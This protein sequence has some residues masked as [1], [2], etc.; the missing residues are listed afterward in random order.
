MGLI[1]AEAGESALIVL[2]LAWANEVMPPD[3]ARMRMVRIVRPNGLSL[4]FILFPPIGRN[5]IRGTVIV[6]VSEIP[7]LDHFPRKSRLN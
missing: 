3:A 7:K 1:A 6:T 2:L 4:D 5:Q